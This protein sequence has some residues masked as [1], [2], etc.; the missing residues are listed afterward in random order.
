MLGSGL[1]SGVASG[2]SGAESI[3][4]LGGIQHRLAGIGHVIAKGLVRGGPVDEDALRSCASRIDD[5]L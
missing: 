2:L 4:A 1:D 3:A 5:G